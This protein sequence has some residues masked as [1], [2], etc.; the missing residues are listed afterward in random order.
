MT[1][2]YTV[3][4]EYQ[5]VHRDFD[6]D[7]RF[8][9]MEYLDSIENDYRAKYYPRNTLWGGVKQAIHRGDTELYEPMCHAGK[10]DLTVN[11]EYEDE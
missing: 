2:K 9:L 7:E 10:D 3:S 8:E 11:I 5:G 4:T 1:I 6:Q